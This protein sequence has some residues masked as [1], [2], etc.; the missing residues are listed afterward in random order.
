MTP[1]DGQPGGNEDHGLVSPYASDRFLHVLKERDLEVRDIH[2]GAGADSRRLLLARPATNRVSMVAA[3]APAGPDATEVSA[4]V[5]EER[6]LEHAHAALRPELQQ[7]VPRVLSRVDLDRSLDARLLTAV[8]GLVVGSG[9]RTTRKSKALLTSVSGWITAVWRD[10]ASG[11][12]VVDLAADDLRNVLER[13]QPIPRLEPA[14]DALRRARMRV[15]QYEAPVTL[16]HGCFCPDHVFLAEGTIGVEDWGAGAVRGNPLRDAG[17]FALEVAGGR[18]PE[19]LA[20]RSGF[21]GDIRHFMSTV[22]METPVPPQLWREVLALTQLELAT[23]SLEHA[24]PNAM[25]LLSRAV[26]LSTALTRTR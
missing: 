7:S 10:T 3:L 18:L 12:A 6:V 21:A 5:N 24:D 26:R 22:L 20:G 16:T 2:A 8:P 13:P 15:A 23:A 17:R 9:R 25:H 14:L 4:V 11:A 19:V 1:Q